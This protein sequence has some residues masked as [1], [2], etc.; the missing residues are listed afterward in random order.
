M[1]RWDLKPSIPGST[2]ANSGLRLVAKNDES[3]NPTPA[4]S[5]VFFDTVFVSDKSLA[6]A[7]MLIV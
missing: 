1:K 6:K 5:P 7:M 2:F 4:K 3:H